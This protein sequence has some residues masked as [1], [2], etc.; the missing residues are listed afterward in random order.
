MIVYHFTGPTLRDGRPIPPIGEWLVHDGPIVPCVQGLHG[1]QHPFDALHYAPGNLL[2]Q[3][4]LDGEIVSHGSPP[5]K[6]VGRRRK[7]LATVDAA[8][9]LLEF[10]RWCALQVAHLRDCPDHVRAFLEPGDEMLRSTARAT[11][12]GEAWATAISA[13]W[14]AARVAAGAAARDVAGAAAWDVAMAAARAAAEEAQRECFAELVQAE[15]TNYFP[16]RSWKDITGF[17]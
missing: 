6:V 14:G 3:C 4:V 5:D 11:A 17:R 2:H 8:G 9:M 12:M 13:A 7:I 10:A 16:A 1:S 15:V